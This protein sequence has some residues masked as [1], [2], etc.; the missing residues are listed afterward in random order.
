MV[1]NKPAIVTN[2]TATEDTRLQLLAEDIVVGAIF[3]FNYSPLLS[4]LVSI[5]VNNR[6]VALRKSVFDKIEWMWVE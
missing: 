5:S 6:I 3:N 4:G 1:E 2:I